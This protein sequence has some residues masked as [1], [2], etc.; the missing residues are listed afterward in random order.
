MP[1]SL[2]ALG[3]EGFSTGLCFVRLNYTAIIN[4]RHSGRNI[5][6]VLLEAL[7]LEGFFVEALVS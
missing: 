5:E 4:V 7:G 1:M 6:G 2:K 3:V